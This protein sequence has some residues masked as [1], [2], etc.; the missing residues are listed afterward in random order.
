MPLRNALLENRITME[1]IIEKAN[2]DVQD[3]IS[4][5]DGGSTVYHYKDGGSSE[6]H[7]KGYTIIKLNKL[8]G[9]RD[10]YIGAK[11]LKLN[12]LNIP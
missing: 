4:Y 9:N 6:Y 11:D 1:E 3:A 5:D 7:N 10:V 2:K 8:D 12:D